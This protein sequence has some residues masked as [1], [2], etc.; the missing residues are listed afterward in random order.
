MIINESDGI[1]R[2]PLHNSAVPDRS[3]VEIAPAI[4]CFLEIIVKGDVE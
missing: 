4:S 1:E 3:H 2:S